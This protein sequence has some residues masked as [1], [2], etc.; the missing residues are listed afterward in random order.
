MLSAPIIRLLQRCKMRTRQEILNMI[1]DLERKIEDQKHH[2][3]FAQNKEEDKNYSRIIF[4]IRQQ[5][6]LLEWVILE[7]E[8]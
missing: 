6:E 8:Q 5:T 2:Q 4:E 1:S 3:K 7:D